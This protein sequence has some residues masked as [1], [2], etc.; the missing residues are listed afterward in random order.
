V[1]IRINKFAVQ[2]NSGEVISSF[3]RAVDEIQAAT[4]TQITILGDASNNILPPPGIASENT[5]IE[6]SGT[7][8]AVY[9]ARVSLLVAF[10]SKAGLFVDTGLSLDP[11]LHYVIAGRKA[12]DL[13]SIMRISQSNI[14]LPSP[15]EVHQ[16]LNH[17]APLGWEVQSALNPEFGKIV[18]TGER[19]RVQQA[20]DLLLRSAQRKLKSEQIHILPRKIDWMLTH[21]KD[22]ILRFM[23]DNGMKISN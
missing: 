22:L 18:I 4:N 1:N 7:R 3:Q 20:K 8:E 19:S 10:D 13:H 11:K 21:Q 6:I 2:N 5:I 12:F 9:R 15:F 23:Y 17:T 16:T 14:Y